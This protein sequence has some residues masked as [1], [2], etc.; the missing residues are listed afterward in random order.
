MK[1]FHII[2]ASVFLA[3]LIYG[4]IRYPLENTEFLVCVFLTTVLFNITVYSGIKLKNGSA[5]K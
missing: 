4:L 3:C 5:N 1:I 2:T